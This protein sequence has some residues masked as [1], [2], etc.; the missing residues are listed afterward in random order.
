ME[1]N[2]HKIAQNQ[3]QFKK[4]KITFFYRKHDL[5]LPKISKFKKMT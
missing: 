5:N 3:L 1:G 2:L 4:E